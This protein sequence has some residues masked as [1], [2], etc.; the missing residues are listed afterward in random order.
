MKIEIKGNYVVIERVI[1]GVTKTFEY[2]QGRSFYFT[3][4]GVSGLDTIEII[5]DISDGKTYVT[6]ADINAGL[7]VD[8]NDAPYTVQ[9]LL[10][11]LQEYTGTF[12]GNNV[13]TT[14]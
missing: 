3:R 11:L 7:I 13:K 5:N 6:V 2:P 9:S 8:E 14:A 10:E 12:V 4:F 1:G